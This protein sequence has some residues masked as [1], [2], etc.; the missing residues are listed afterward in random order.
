MWHAKLNRTR[1]ASWGLAALAL[2]LIFL[3]AGGEPAEA[4]GGLSADADTCVL[5]FPG[6][7]YKMHFTGYQP[8][9]QQ[10]EFCEDIPERGTTIVAIDYFSPELRRMEVELR[11]IRDPEDPSAETKN[12]DAITELYLP[13]QKRPTGTFNF[14][15]E[16]V[17]GNYIGFLKLNDGAKEHV[18]RFPFAVGVAPRSS[19]FYFAVFLSLLLAAGGTLIWAVRTNR[20]NV[21]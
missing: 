10:R 14:Q 12:M 16:F 20:L 5:R 7:S 19:T 4:H 9:S 13:P 18:S 17:E 3:G 2:V 6:T 8:N 1:H 11:V 21:R 15:H